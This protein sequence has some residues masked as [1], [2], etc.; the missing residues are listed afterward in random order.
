MKKGSNLLLV[1]IGIYI[2][3]AVVV[4]L[5]FMPKS[6]G[7]QP[8]EPESVKA[9]QEARTIG[10]ASK[11]APVDNTW[12]YSDGT[13]TD[14]DLADQGLPIPTVAPEDGEEGAPTS[15]ETPEDGEEAAATPTEA[16]GAEEAE[17]TEAAEDTV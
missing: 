3:I 1:M 7:D 11:D 8:K 12:V 17:P 13:I 5:M 2:V 10:D 16:P 6:T 14:E 9:G 4:L 15:T